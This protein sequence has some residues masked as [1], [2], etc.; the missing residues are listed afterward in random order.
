MFGEPYLL[1]LEA[2]E[3]RKARE[4]AAKEALDAR[5]RPINWINLTTHQLDA[6]A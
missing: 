2:E 1:W 5:F 6:L 4:K 3:E